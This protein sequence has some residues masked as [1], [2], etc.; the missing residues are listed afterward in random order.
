VEN[1][2]QEKEK[3][4]V[5]MIAARTTTALKDYLVTLE[6]SEEFVKFRE[7]LEKHYR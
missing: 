7:K 6:G 3:A 2:R 5:A 1:R 4:A